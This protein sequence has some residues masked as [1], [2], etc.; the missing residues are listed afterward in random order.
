MKIKWIQTFSRINGINL[1]LYFYRI[2]EIH[3]HN[4][5]AKYLDGN[6]FLPVNNDIAPMTIH[7]IPLPSIAVLRTLSETFNRKNYLFN[8]DLID[9]LIDCL[10][11]SMI[12]VVDGTSTLNM[13]NPAI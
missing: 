11:D 12:D 2:I 4:N 8:D 1:P 7:I 6:I 9:W 5:L 3:L 13:S 10:I